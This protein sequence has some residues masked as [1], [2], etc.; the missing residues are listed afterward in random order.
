MRTKVLQPVLQE[1]DAS[2]LAALDLLRVRLQTDD[3]E[4]AQHRD[5]D[6]EGEVERRTAVFLAAQ[7]RV[8]GL[9]FGEQL[10]DRIANRPADHLSRGGGRTTCESAA[11]RRL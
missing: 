2:A 11:M 10:H 4:S 7:R 9:D 1:V 3:E 8:R 6:G 5:A